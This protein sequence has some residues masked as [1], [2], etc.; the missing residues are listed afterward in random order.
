MDCLEEPLEDEAAQMPAF[1]KAFRAYSLTLKD[2][3]AVL[4][5]IRVARKFGLTA[6][7]LANEFECLCST[8][9]VGEACVSLCTRV[10]ADS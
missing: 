2:A 3:A 4:A 7:T 9:W 6:S 10:C 8:K 1:S 5:C